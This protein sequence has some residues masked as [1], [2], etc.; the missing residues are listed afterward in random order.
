MSIWTRVLN[1]FRGDRVSREIDEEL[2][3]HVAA[4]I[5]AGRDPAEARRAFGC[6]LRKSEE[7]R[8]LKLIP[9]LDSV[10]ADVIFGWRQIKKK[11]VAS[12]A[13]ILSLGLAI[14]ACASAF[15][16]IDAV[17]LRPLPV[18][19]PA[20]LYSL[21][22]QGVGFDDKPN[23]Y[24]SWAYPAFTLMRAAVRDQAEL[25]AVSYAQRKDLTYQSDQETERAFVQYVSGW[26]FGTFGLRP[27]LGRLLLE[28]DDR[29][30]GAHPYAVLSH[31]YWARRFGLD[32]KVIGRALRLDGKTYEIVGV[33]EEPFTGVET[34]TVTDI[35]VPTMMHPG[36]THSDWTWFRTLAQMK[37]GAALEPLRAKLHA[38]SR[39]FEEER[40][41]GFGGMSKK[42]RERFLNENVLLRPAAAGASGLQQDYRRSLMA[43][44]TLV[45]LVLVIACANVANLLAAQ[46]AARAREMALRVSIGAGRWRLVQLVMIE[47]AWLALLAA[48]VG[49]LF[50]VWSAPLVVG[51]INP[52]DNPARLALPLDWRVLGFGIGLTL[53]VTLLFGLAPAIRASGVKPA[54]ALKGGDDP[55]ARQRLTH[56]LIGVQVA[57]GV[58]VLFLAGLLVVT[59][60]RLSRRP[61]GFSAARVVALETVAQ[62]AQLPAIW[63]QVMERLRAEPGVESV[64]LAGWPLLGGG[65]WNNFISLNG[66][67]PGPTL[68]YFL[69]I[70]P[71]WIETMKIPLLQGRDFRTTD[72]SPGVALINETFAREFFNGDHPVGKVFAKG[73]DRYE[74]VGVVRDTPYRQMREQTL[75]QVFVPFHGIRADGTLAPIRNE[76]IMARVSADNPR[77]LDSLLRAAVSAARPD[78]RV[79]TIRLQ[80][81]INQSHTIRERLMA[82]LAAFFALVALVIAG[83]GVYGVLDYSVV[84]RRREL[85]IRLALG[86]RAPNI[87]V[88]VTG[89]VLVMVV[90]G[91]IAGLALGLFSA[92]Y[93]EALFYQVRPSEV[94]AVAG[95]L[96]AILGAAILAALPPVIRAVRIDPVILLR[97]E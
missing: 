61:T 3:A 65:S 87:A 20:R 30:P 16:L 5:E 7:S 27:A 72:T 75:P 81:E 63:D 42:N 21:S 55:H 64:S 32:P 54:S 12:A 74:V 41:K 26:M 46:A 8:D 11:K 69:E 94:S 51:M 52:P 6:A 36:V 15:R 19:D 88:I 44:A 82:R 29:E 66:A 40:A 9:W 59:F 25:V 14:G 23:E 50:A 68:A 31:D 10:R 57:F 18:A 92:R 79:S 89:G 80:S 34:G 84:Q 56:A 96:L 60:D 33:T 73:N 38:T 90:I 83:V 47:S 97:A 49:A 85:G 43:L 48:G 45:S 91:V 13:A 28:A 22:R 53:F 95:P 17:L 58:L 71:G 86:A 78:F 35:F 2:E 70:S 62:A 76:T 93:L 77:A 37:P 39:A 24:D 1:V 4:A 67:P